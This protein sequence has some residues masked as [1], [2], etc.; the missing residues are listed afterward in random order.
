[1]HLPV[2]LLAATLTAHGVSAASVPQRMHAGRD[3]NVD[4]FADDWNAN[5][6]YGA[7]SLFLRRG[8]R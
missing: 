3:Q 7:F 2:L 5:S 6:E 8:D 4:D 1:M